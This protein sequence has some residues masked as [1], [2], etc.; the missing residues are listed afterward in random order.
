MATPVDLDRGRETS[1]DAGM[2]VNVWKPSI[3]FVQDDPARRRD[4][5]RELAE[6]GIRTVGAE[7][8]ASAME[9]LAA[10]PLTFALLVTDLDVMPIGGVSLARVVHRR[11]PDLPVAIISGAATG[12]RSLGP[13]ITL[14]ARPVVPGQLA[15]AIARL[16]S[17][18]Q[19]AQPLAVLS[20]SGWSFVP[21][22]VY[23]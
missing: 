19:S 8:V 21:L 10:N 15:E 14:L 12:T 3:L 22:R 16:V 9:A 17:P 6:R 20:E 1:D 11:W 7:D 18:G 4:V 13:G 5:T 2:E 23:P